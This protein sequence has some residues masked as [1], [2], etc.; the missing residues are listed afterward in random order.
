MNIQSKIYQLVFSWYS[1]RI[2]SLLFS[3][4]IQAKN[5]LWPALT[6]LPAISRDSRRVMG[7][8]LLSNYCLYTL[9]IN[10]L[11]IFYLF[12]I[13]E[14][15]LSAISFSADNL[16]VWPFLR[17]SAWFFLF[18]NRLKVFLAIFWWF[19]YLILVS[20]KHFLYSDKFN[21][22]IKHLKS[23]EKEFASFFFFT[24]GSL[25]LYKLP[26]G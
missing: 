3:L 19:N 26:A 13:L 18:L 22:H 25:M 6:W 1:F 23:I 10:H 20:K 11:Y 4:F 2:F 24:F 7:L 5:L 16:H 21:F 12:L 15:Q 17:L 14:L 8:K 9:D